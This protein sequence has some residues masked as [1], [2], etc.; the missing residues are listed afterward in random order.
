MTRDP[1]VEFRGWFLVT[2]LPFADPVGGGLEHTRDGVRDGGPSE[3]QSQKKWVKT[4][5]HL[6]R[7]F[8]ANH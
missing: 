5:L 1:A 4:E 7:G 8:G 6:Q 2:P 3:L